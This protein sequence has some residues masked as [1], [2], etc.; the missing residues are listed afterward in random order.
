MT[1]RWLCPVILG[2]FCYTRRNFRARVSS[3]GNSESK[4][5]LLLH[6]CFPAPSMQ[7]FHVDIEL[8]RSL[9]ASVSCVAYWNDSWFFL[10][11]WGSS[12][13]MAD[14]RSSFMTKAVCGISPKTP[15]QTV[16]SETGNLP[17]QI[18]P[19]ESIETEGDPETPHKVRIIRIC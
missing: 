6:A 13:F 7:I 16:F 2:C 5:Q 4:E 8:L 1:V 19:L 3:I 17:L 12:D 10:S 14:P 18:T 9:L 15:N 11:I